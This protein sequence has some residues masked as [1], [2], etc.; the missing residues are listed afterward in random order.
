VITFDRNAQAGC[1]PRQQ[2]V[3]FTNRLARM[4]DASEIAFVAVFLASDKGA[5]QLGISPDDA[6]RQDF[7]SD[8]PRGNAICRPG[9]SP[10]S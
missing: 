8:A 5:T 10:A 6:E 7:A 1:R 9:R 4:V 3:R 2:A